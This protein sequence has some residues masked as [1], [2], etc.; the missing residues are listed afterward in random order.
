[1][2]SVRHRSG[3]TGARRRGRWHSRLVVPAAL[4]AAPANDQFAD[5]EALS[6]ASG[7]ATGSNVEATKEP[8]SP[9]TPATRAAPLVWYR[10]TASTGQAVSFE[11]CGSSFDTTLAVY[12]GSTLTTLDAVAESDDACALGSRVTFDPVSGTTYQIAIDGFEGAT[13]T[14]ALAWSP[15]PAPANDDFAAAEVLSGSAGSIYA[16]NLGATKEPA[17]SA[18]RA[19]PAATRSGSAGPTPRQRR[20]PS[21][22]A[23]PL[24]HAPRRLYRH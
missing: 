18:H 19:I 13:G 8:G 5:A 4:A 2:Q 17:E 12:T 6:G 24:R 11:T 7:S 10:W 1:M 3:G 22:C 15:V 21:R 9:T 16:W 20:P 23:A 14:I